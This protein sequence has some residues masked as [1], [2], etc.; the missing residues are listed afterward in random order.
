ML[1]LVVTGAVCVAVRYRARRDVRMGLAD[2]VWRL[3][4]LIEAETEGPGATLRVA[5]PSP[6][7]HCRIFREDLRHSNLRIRPRRLSSAGTRELVAVADAE[8]E[9]RLAVRFDLEL[10]PRARWPADGEP[11]S[12]TAEEKAEY[13][14]VDG[15]TAADSRIVEETLQRLRDGSVGE[16]ELL[17]R[18]F[19]HCRSEIVAGDEGAPEEAADVLR[20]GVATSLGRARAMTVLCRA[21]GI[22]ARLVTGFEIRRGGDVVPHVWVEVLTQRRWVPYDPVRGFSGELPYNFVPA[23]RGGARIL[24][25]DGVF[26]AESEFSIERLVGVPRELTAN[27]RS[28]GDILDLTRLPLE[29]HQVISVILLMPLGALVTCVFRNVVGIET[30]GRFTPMLLALS[31]VFADWRTGLVVLAAVVVLGFSTRSFL[32]RL[33]L[34][35]LP[36]LSVVLTLVVC[37]MVFG[38]SL[39]DYF[40]LT[41]GV[42]AV[43]L[44]MVILTMIVERFF[45][46]AEEDG[47][48]VAVQRLAATGL[49]GFVCYLVLRWETVAQLL[50]IYPEVHLFTVAALILIGRYTG[51][52]LL[53]PWRFRD[54]VEIR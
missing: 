4:Y 42:Y 30:S 6:T 7:P 12:L 9:C 34:L 32:E 40:R 25:A 31:F 24:L 36:R 19:E 5:F 43:L 14:E 2:S 51:Y 49:V 54:S 48:H 15:R 16:G 18:L 52:Q 3:S 10:S 50:L 11:I 27:A 41:P 13:L 37:C 8:D 26:D 28:P 22:P 39:L 38:V 21:G 23:R 1:V 44:P 53:E 33:K 20:E 46:T 17:E 45:V 29:M 47:M 35:M